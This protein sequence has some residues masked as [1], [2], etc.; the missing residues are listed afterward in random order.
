MAAVELCQTEQYLHTCY[1]PHDTAG[2]HWSTH[3]NFLESAQDSFLTGICFLPRPYKL[4]L[5][6]ELCMF[7]FPTMGGLW[8]ELDL[9][10]MDTD[11]KNDPNTCKKK[12][13]TLLFYIQWSPCFFANIHRVI[14]RI[15]IILTSLRYQYAFITID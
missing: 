10:N 1:P 6:V 11:V 13:G 12:N 4:P 7:H 14:V 3:H 8:N 2:G 9:K 5:K 15:K